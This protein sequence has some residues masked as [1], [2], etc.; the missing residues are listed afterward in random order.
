MN[1]VK[2]VYRLLRANKTSDFVWNDLKQ[3]MEKENFH[4][5]VFESNKCIE[6]QFNNNDKSIGTYFISIYEESNTITGFTNI[7]ESYNDDRTIDLFVLASHFNSR[8]NKGIVTI[9]TES[10]NVSFMVTGDLFSHSIFPENSLDMLEYLYHSSNDIRWAF[11]RLLTTD[12]DPVF[13]FSEL[14]DRKS[15]SS[16]SEK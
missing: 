9:N 12:Q 1:V 4:N 6:L 14:L 13:V 15:D 3:T 5:G 16:K 10:S 2:K 7:I 11:N 8:L